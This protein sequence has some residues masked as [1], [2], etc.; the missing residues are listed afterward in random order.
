M[1]VL[2]EKFDFLCA[3]VSLE[4]C[5]DNMVLL[6]ALMQS[7]VLIFPILV[8]VGALVFIWYRWWR[9]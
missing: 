5:E 7:A 4:V 1:L 9:R 2:L 6:V 8:L 3:G